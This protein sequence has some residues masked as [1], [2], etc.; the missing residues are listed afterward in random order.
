[1]DMVVDLD[2]KDECE[3]KTVN[4]NTAEAEVRGVVPI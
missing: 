3:G 4:G 2:E 1:V